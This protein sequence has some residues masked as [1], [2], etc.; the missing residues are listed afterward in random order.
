MA[1]ETAVKPAPGLQALPSMGAGL[2]YRAELTRDILQNLSDI[3]VLEF[4]ADRLHGGGEREW[5][6]LKDLSELVP[7]IPHGVNLSIGSVDCLKETGYLDSV[8]R[9]CRWLD[10]PYYSEH[11][12]LTKHGGRD[13]GNLTPL[14]STREQLGV[15]VHNIDVIQ[16]LIGRPLVMEIIT[17][18]FEIPEADM[19]CVEFVN[20]AAA[21]T[22][23]GLLLDIANIFFNGANFG[24]DPR[25]FVDDLNLHAVTQ[26]HLAGGVLEAGHWIDSHSAPVQPEV[27]QLYC[28]IA[29]RC[30]NLKAVIV[31][32]D[33]RLEG[34]FPGLMAEVGRAKDIWRPRSRRWNGEVI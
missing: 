8:E 11:F 31:E 34:S 6:E 1:V 19:S 12:A 23:C 2:G 26:F 27:W 13:F 20:E 32:R 7:L 18:P 9:L 28:E 25:K 21:R 14:W 3:D 17:L 33:A 15:V 29:P 4:S 24:L 22:G 16:E 5:A 30:R 10:V